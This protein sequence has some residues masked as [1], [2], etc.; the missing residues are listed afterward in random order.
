MD[1][2]GLGLEKWI[3]VQLRYIVFPFREHK[4]V[5]DVTF[6]RNILYVRYLQTWRRAG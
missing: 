5:H 1:W 3:H 6:F 2:I 4:Y